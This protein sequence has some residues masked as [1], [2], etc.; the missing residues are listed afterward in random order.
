M[1][2]ISRFVC[3]FQNIKMDDVKNQGRRPVHQ[4][5]KYDWDKGLYSELIQ[6]LISLESKCSR[7]RQNVSVDRARIS[8]ISSWGKSPTISLVLLYRR[9]DDLEK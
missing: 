2:T 5:R 8:L 9:N 6:R 4:F 7:S 1:T 3:I